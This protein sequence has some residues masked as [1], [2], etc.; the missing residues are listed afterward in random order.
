M[1]VDEARDHQPAAGID[2]LSA[3]CTRRQLR[4]D[5][6]DGVVAHEDVA[7]GQIAEFGVDSDE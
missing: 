1:G 7:V 5:C 2:Y 6:G 4:A 3:G